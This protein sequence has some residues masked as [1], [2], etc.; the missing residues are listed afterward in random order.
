MR[1]R[2]FQY[3]FEYCLKKFKLQCFKRKLKKI[4]F[5][6]LKAFSLI[7]IFSFVGFISF[8]GFMFLV[9]P[10]QETSEI[11]RRSLTKKPDFSLENLF[12]G[13]YTDDYSLYYSDNFSFREKFVEM[14]FLLEE[15]RGL[16]LGS[17]KIYNSGVTSKDVSI[18]ASSDI[19]S[20]DSFFETL[21][22]SR[23][24]SVSLKIGQ[25]QLPDK[26]YAQITN[27]SE[28]ADLTKED[29]R[30][31]QRG[32]LFIIGDA[33]LEIFYGNENV[34]KDY[35]STINAF[36]KS[37][38]QSIRM[39]NAIIPTHF[40][41]GLPSKYHSSVGKRQKPFITDI[42]NNLDAGI[43]AIDVYSTIQKHYNKGEYLYFRSDHHWTSLGA[44]YAYTQFAQS[45]GFE[46]VS[47]EQYEKKKIDKFLGTFYS[48]SFDKNLQ[49][50]PDF[51]EYYMPFTPY[52]MINY[53]ENGVDTYKGTMI[54]ENI[55]S[56]SAGYL[57]FMGGDI[58]L[59]I[60]TTDNNSGRSIIVFKESYGN[61]F[62]PFLLAHYDKV[63]VADIRTFPFDA[64]SYITENNITDVLFIN[65]IMT[66]CIPARVMNIINLTK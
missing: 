26:V 13:S 49:E 46:P 23:I 31:E 61:A 22:Q 35:T 3:F 12:S 28:Y 53:R 63:F 45:A 40:E 6:I 10:K 30:G 9:L 11:E 44:Y 19:I 43:S 65:N 18:E 8:L 38:P 55:S 14:S 7:T 27:E 50:N 32:P 24:D 59:S 48:G 41:F 21:R 25:E 60:S 36:R 20:K 1:L 52:N 2:F 57:V 29:L 39:Y 66:S 37:L 62:V 54:Y 15:K 17:V 33:A 64:I 42:Y 56:I 16:R 47:I 34:A 51:V 4:N 5:L 58:P